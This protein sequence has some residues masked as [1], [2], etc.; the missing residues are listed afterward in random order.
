MAKIKYVVKKYEPSD[1]QE[2]TVGFYAAAKINDEVTTKDLA[3]KLAPKVAYPA[4]MIEGILACAAD[5]IAQECLE[6]NRVKLNGSAGKV[7]VSIYP[8]VV[9]SV[10]QTWVE[11]QIEAGKLPSG[12]VVSASLLTRDKLSVIAGASMGTDFSKYLNQNASLEKYTAS[13]SN[14]DTTDGGTTGGSTGGEN[15]GGSNPNNPTDPGQ[16]GME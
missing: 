14:D 3:N 12:T 13:A 10:S 11:A 2:G 16:E 6:S 5:Q 1:N 9:G 8:K 7:M 15:G 4:P